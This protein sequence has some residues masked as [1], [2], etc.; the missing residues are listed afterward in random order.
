MKKAILIALSVLPISAYSAQMVGTSRAGPAGVQRPG[1]GQLMRPT[2][3]VTTTTTTAV[4]APAVD[5]SNTSSATVNIEYDASVKRAECLNVPGNVWA[6]KAYSSFDGVANA[7]GLPQAE[8][9]SDNVC[10]VPV[11]IRSSEI[12]DIARFFPTRYFS[13]GTAAECG[14]WIDG[15]DLDKAILD[16]KKGARVGGTVA[17]SVIGAGAGF[18]LAEL[19]GQNGLLIKDFKGQASMKRE[20]QEQLSDF[21]KS[22]A[23]SD[24]GQLNKYTEGVR[25]FVKQCNKEGK[26]PANCTKADAY[27]NDYCDRDYEKYCAVL[28][29]LDNP[30]N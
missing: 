2:V 6:N 14:S 8:K 17:A 13:T 16:A 7:A 3:P 20:T 18:G 4:S 12:K 29:V 28:K 27:D 30:E 19:L 23:R 5:E 25:D 11:A 22:L 15:K 24:P 10:Y 26:A 1:S 21:V 9:A